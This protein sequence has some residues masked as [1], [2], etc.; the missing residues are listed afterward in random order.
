[1]ERIS[2]GFIGSG[3]MATA[4]A[5]GL[6]TAGLVTAD[7]ILAS[8]PNAAA[9]RAFEDQVSGCRIV[10]DNGSLARDADVLVLA[11][12]PA[13]LDEATRACD[14]PV[15]GKLVM[16]IVAG[17]RLD[18]LADRLGT[19]RI[20]RVMPNAPC[21]VGFGA[22]GYACGA[23][24]DDVDARRI[25]S[26]LEAVGMCERVPESQLDAVTGLS[27]SGPAFVAAFLEAMIDGGVLMGLPRDVATRL[28]VQTVRGTS[29]WM[30]RAGCHPAEI[31]DR[32]AS[33]GGTTIAGLKALEVR[34]FRGA[35]LAAVEE[36]TRRATELGMPPRP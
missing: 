26:M 6:V 21:L 27:G 16:S 9:R 8:D 35:V 12:K 13:H 25:E 7:R 20:V 33:P 2:I 15:V 28:A 36:A 18:D 5:R 11:V 17:A 1:M 32:V 34:A 19:R 10:P 22:A 31:K 24:V 4:L 23:D 3:R 29:E 14:P 30:A